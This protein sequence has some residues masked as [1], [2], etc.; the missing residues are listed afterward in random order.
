MIEEKSRTIRREPARLRGETHTVSRS[1]DERTRRRFAERGQIGVKKGGRLDRRGYASRS[2]AEVARNGTDDWKK[3]RF[4]GDVSVPMETEQTTAGSTVKTGADVAG[5][6]VG[7]SRTASG[8]SV[9]DVH[10]NGFTD[11]KRGA[12]RTNHWLHLTIEDRTPK[13]MNGWRVRFGFDWT[14]ERQTVTA[15]T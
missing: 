8:S 15:T 13:R 7:A 9:A 12:N 10:G 14:R 2:H 1:A 4:E 5:T 11:G 3:N 6:T